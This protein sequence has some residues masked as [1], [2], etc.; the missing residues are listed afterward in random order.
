M[1]PREGSASP[2]SRTFGS[3]ALISF[4]LVLLMVALVRSSHAQSRGEVQVTAHVISTV[5]GR[6]AMDAAVALARGQARAQQQHL[7]RVTRH[8]PTESARPDTFTRKEQLVVVEFLA[9]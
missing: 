6:S 8:P 5:E 9:N 7:F 3:Q 1:R 4:A 2:E